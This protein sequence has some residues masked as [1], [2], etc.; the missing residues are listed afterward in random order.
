MTTFDSIVEQAR[1]LT[2]ADRL[3]LARLLL[4]EAKIENQTDEIGV[5]E[6]GLSA[7][8]DSTRGEDWSDV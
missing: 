4:E 6:R 8:S 1:S 3:R 7:W 5:G 2:L